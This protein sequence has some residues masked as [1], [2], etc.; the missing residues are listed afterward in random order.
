MGFTLVA[1]HRSRNVV[2]CRQGQI[3]FIMN[4]KPKS[5]AAYVVAEHG[6]GVCGMA[7]QVQNAH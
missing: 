1:E 7:F 2:L 5:V 3:N 4:R 6:P